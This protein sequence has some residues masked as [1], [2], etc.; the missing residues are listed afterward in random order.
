M[1]DFT[2]LAFV[3]HLSLPP[4]NSLV[5]SRTLEKPNARPVFY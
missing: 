2:M 1:S 3:D 4:V 5:L